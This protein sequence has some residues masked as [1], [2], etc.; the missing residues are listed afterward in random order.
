[1]E[2][3]PPSPN[4]DGAVFDLLGPNGHRLPTSGVEMG[5][6]PLLVPVIPFRRTSEW[7]STL[8]K[9][10]NPFTVTFDLTAGYGVKCADFALR[11]AAVMTIVVVRGEEPVDFPELR[12]RIQLRIVVCCIR[13]F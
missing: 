4:H 5:A 12:K 10:Q 3:V 2:D 1:M 8:Y 7:N 13:P 6:G 9:Q 11:S